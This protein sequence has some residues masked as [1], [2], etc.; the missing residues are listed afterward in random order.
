MSFLYKVKNKIQ[1]INKN[2]LIKKYNGT[3]FYDTQNTIVISGMPR[4]GSTWFAELLNTDKKSAIIWE[5]LHLDFYPPIK[6]LNFKWRQYIPENNTD[7]KILEEFK[8]IVT[9]HSLTRGILQRTTIQQL[10]NADYLIIK[11]CRANRLLPWLTKQFAFKK[12]IHLLRHPCA[13]VASQMR[14]GAWN[15]V[16][17][18]FT[19]EELKPDGFIENYY[20]ILKPIHTKEEK[21]AAIWCLD[22]IIPL[23]QNHHARWVSITYENLLLYPEKIFERIELPFTEAIQQKFYK[24]STTTKNGSP[25]STKESAVKQLAY[26]KQTLTEPQI[27]AILNVV[28]KFGITIYNTEVYPT[29]DY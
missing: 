17:A 5:P 14:F 15:D 13:V 25:V 16:D 29:V 7:E 11:F 26:W 27:N 3:F 24:P 8:K 28:Q 19:E 9:G 6:K 1:F 4:G 18:Y 10:Q 22:N 21:L 2:R 12:T 20:S 23:T